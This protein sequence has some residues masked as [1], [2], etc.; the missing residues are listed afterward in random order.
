MNIQ[1]LDYTDAFCDVGENIIQ[2]T[3]IDRYI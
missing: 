2:L 3:D 1:E